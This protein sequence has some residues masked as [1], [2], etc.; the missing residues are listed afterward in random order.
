MSKANRRRSRN[1]DL[2]FAAVCF[3]GF[4]EI[5]GLG[6]NQTAATIRAA[7]IFAVCLPVLVGAALM[8]ALVANESETRGLTWGKW[9]VLLFDIVSSLASIGGFLGIH[10]LFVAVSPDAASGF[11]TAS[12]VFLA[13]GVIWQKYLLG[14]T[15][16]RKQS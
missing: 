13:V 5:F 2:G 8:A 14:L 4:L 7:N 10:S 12:M 3:A 1:V 16:F 11:M 9:V 6:A 15:L